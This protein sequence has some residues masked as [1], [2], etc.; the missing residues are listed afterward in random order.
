[1]ASVNHRAHRLPTRHK[2]ELGMR[3]RQA[4]VLTSPGHGTG[5]NVLRERQPV[6]GWRENAVAPQLVDEVFAKHD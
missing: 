5:A 3:L 1:M 2:Q 6:A 4:L